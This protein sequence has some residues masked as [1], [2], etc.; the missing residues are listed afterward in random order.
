MGEVADT[1]TKKKKKGRPSLLDLQKRAIKQ[2]QQQLQQQQQQHKNNHQD[3]DD[4][5]HNNNNRS[6]SKNPNSLN[7]RSKRRNP[8]SNDGDSPWIKDEGEDNDDDERREKK[9]KLLHGLNSH[10]HRHSPNSQSDLNLDQTPEPS[11]NRRNL[12]AAASGSDYHTG[13]KASK[14]TDILQGSPV[15]SGPTTPLP[16]KKLLLFILDR[17]QKKDTYGVYSDPVDP[18]ELPDYF[19]IIK[20]PMDFSTL[21][22]KLDSGAYSTLE[23]F[24]RDVFLICTNAMEYNSA[25]TVYY[26][27]A[28]AI[29]ELAKKDFENLRQDSDDEEPQSQQQQQQQPKVARRGRPPKKH[30]EPSS[31]DRTASEI[32]ADALIPGDSSNKFSGAYNLRKAPPSYKFRQA[33]SSVRINH[34]SETQSGWS[35]DWESEFPSSVV[36]AVNKYGMKHFNVDDNRRDTY[37]HLSTSTQEP[38]VLTT[39]EDE[40]KQLIPVGLNMEYGYAKSLARYAANLG[41]VAW[42]IA[43]RRIETVLPSGIKFGQGWVGENP[44]GPEEDDSQKQNILMSSGKQKCSNDL[45]SDDHSNR[46]LSPTASVS[47]AFIGNRHAS[48]QAIEET[49]PPPAR[50]LN[51][52]IDHPSSSS[53]QAGLLIK[54]ESSNGLIRG[55]NHNANQMLGIARQQQPNVSNEATPVSQQQGSLFPY[56]KQEFHRFPPDLNARLVSPNSPGSNQ[57]TGSSSSQ[58]PDLALQL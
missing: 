9:H 36:K 29:Q 58:H 24:E 1:M 53:H 20:N 46:I 17:L 52:E 51:P 40:L 16:D 54:T 21:R 6:G 23:Q 11:F 13:E 3:D 34:N 2:Q 45:A 5:H 49:T 25:D 15:E 18:E 57:Q 50:V 8:N 19:E 47:S 43:S 28:R 4:H 42:K 7:H 22:N 27:Q 33:E 35:V 48:S 26:R 39:L 44:A 55:F 32:S 31:I 30:P 56:P 38:S 10:S 14:A 41:P 12:S 37:N